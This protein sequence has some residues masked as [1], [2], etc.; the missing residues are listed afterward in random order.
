[1][2]WFPCLFSVA[3]CGGNGLGGHCQCGTY[4]GLLDAKIMFLTTI[5]RPLP[6]SLLFPCLC[7]LGYLSVSTDGGTFSGKEEP[8]AMYSRGA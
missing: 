1:M 8:L 7:Y 3:L 5:Y 2:S 4:L 6:A